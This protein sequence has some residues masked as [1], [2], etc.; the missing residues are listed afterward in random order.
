MPLTQ[1]TVTHTVK[2]ADGSPGQGTIIF[3][4]TKRITNGADTI[5]PMPQAFNLDASGALS[6]LLYANDDA[7]TTPGDSRYKVDF[8]LSYPGA[9]EETFFITVPSGSSPVDLGSLLPQDQYGG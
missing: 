9:Q 4:L 8:R 3:T 1:V 6:A 7:G 2:N 5:L